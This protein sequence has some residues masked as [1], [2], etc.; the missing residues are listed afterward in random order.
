MTRLIDELGFASE[1]M[2]AASPRRIATAY[3]RSGR[4][5]HPAGLNFGDC[6]A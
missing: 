2:T 1:P 4:G 3:G 5:V 6:F